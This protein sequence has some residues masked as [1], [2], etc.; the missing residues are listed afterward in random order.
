M[1]SLLSGEE[2]SLPQTYLVFINGTL[3]GV[4]RQPALLVRNFRLLRR[5][6]LISPFVSVYRNAGQR[7]VYLSSDA[8]RV[9]RPYLI[10]ENGRPRVTP[11]DLRLLVDRGLATPAAAA[12]VR[13]SIEELR[14]SLFAQ[15]L[16]TAERISERRIRDRIAALRRPG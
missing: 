15:Q 2:F 8:G 3:L 6:N 12:P 10:V 4:T 16:G 11:E 7:C 1:V 5:A 9:C 13:W 14:V